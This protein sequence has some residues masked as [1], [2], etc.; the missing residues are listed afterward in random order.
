MPNFFVRKRGLCGKGLNPK[1]AIDR[2][3]VTTD[4][5]EEVWE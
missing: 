1:L 4:K 5:I 3:C 2:S